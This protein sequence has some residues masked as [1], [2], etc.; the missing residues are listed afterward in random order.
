MNNSDISVQPNNTISTV[1][2]TGKRTYQ[3]VL[4]LAIAVNV[5]GLF[6]RFFTNDPGL[7]ALLAKTMVQS[8]NYTDLMYHGKDW[9]DKPHFPFWM[10]ALSFK[11][12]GINT[13]A[14]KLPALLFFFVS[15]TYTYKLAKK[16]YDVETA[17]IAILILLTAQHVVMSNT[18]V[19]AEPYIMGLIMGSVYHFYN[20]KQKFSVADLLIASLFAACAVMTKGIYV[21]IPIGMAIIGEYIFTRN[22]KGLLQWRWVLAIIL[23]ALFTLPEVYTL[24]AQF[25]THPEKVV[26]NH[27][28]VSG[29]HWFLWDSQFGRFNSTGYISK[30][31][32][33]KFFFIHTLLWAFAPWALLLYAALFLNIRKIAKGIA[34]PEYVTL[35]G[36][37]PM[38]LIFSVSAFQLPFYTNILFPFFAIITAVFVRKAIADNKGGYFKIT[39]YIITGALIVLIVAVDFVFA[40]EHSVIFLV[41]SVMLIII[42]VY[43]FR[44]NKQLRA[45]FLFTCCVSIWANTYIEAVVYPDLVGYKGDVQAAEYINQHIAPNDKIIVTCDIPDPFEFYTNRPVYFTDIENALSSRDKNSIILIDDALKSHLEK[46]QTSFSIIKKFDNYPNENLTLPFIIE[47]KRNQTLNNYFLIRLNSVQN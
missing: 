22:F 40:P 10:A 42:T 4:L 36:A 6:I 47:K 15:V 23:V 7:Y 16:L 12:F 34:L 32:G 44:N 29:I 8:N 43:I 46:M 2:S 31:S 37:I 9:L 14:Y 38:F 39:Q 5:A 20:L 41:L 21:L 27:T 24:Y 33:D 25:D 18:D 17:L 1:S 26:F 13:V 3:L 30:P 19:R 11:A 45:I 35:S 28:H